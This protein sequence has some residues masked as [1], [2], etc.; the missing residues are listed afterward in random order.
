MAM[1]T[2]VNAIG[3][4]D[5][6]IAAGAIRSTV[7]DVL[8]GWPVSTDWADVDVLFF[9]A[10][11]IAR[12]PEHAAEARLARLCPGPR[13]EVRNQARMHRKVGNPPYSNTEDGL[14]HFAETPTA[15]GV[16]L[17][18]SEI[19]ILAPHALEDLFGCTVRP[20]ATDPRN[21]AF[22]RARM[23]AKNWPYRWP[24]VRVL[25]L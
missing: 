17:E 12:E 21:M 9:D 8:H 20:T 13:W 1:L 22:Y 5:C 16:R 14:R 15:V 7:W 18:G 25:G 11:D 24:M 3:L 10:G 23:A 19:D 2:A 6:C 4:P